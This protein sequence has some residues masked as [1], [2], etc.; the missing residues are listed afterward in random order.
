MDTPYSWCYPQR[1]L[2]DLTLL[3]LVE[4]CQGCAGWMF[5]GRCTPCRMLGVG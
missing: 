4:R 3:V 5:R 2:A 1:V